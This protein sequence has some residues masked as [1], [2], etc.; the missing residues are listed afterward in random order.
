[1]AGPGCGFVEASDVHQVV[2]VSLGVLGTEFE[3]APEHPDGCLGDVVLLKE[4]DVQ[5]P[6][7]VVLGHGE[8]PQGSEMKIITKLKLAHAFF[9]TFSRRPKQI[10][11]YKTLNF[12]K[13]SLGLS[14][15]TP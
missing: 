12:F 11:L 4:P 10:E 9:V 2:D 15:G 1:M 6:D 7:S 13:N 5:G 3:V 14:P 8:R